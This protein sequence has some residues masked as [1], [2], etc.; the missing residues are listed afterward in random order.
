MAG[1]DGVIIGDDH[2]GLTCAARL[3]DVFRSQPPFT[4]VEN[5]GPATRPTS[6][7]APR[8]GE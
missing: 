7:P 2:I 6:V 8:R 3:R 4:V 1:F 5:L